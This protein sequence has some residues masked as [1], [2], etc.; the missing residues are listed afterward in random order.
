METINYFNASFPGYK[1][2]ICNWLSK[3]R[4]LQVNALDIK[5]VLG[6][7]F[8][9]DSFCHPFQCVQLA[10]NLLNIYEST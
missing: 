9:T 4:W 7:A 1:F 2:G 3:F 8:L 10:V 5:T 6:I